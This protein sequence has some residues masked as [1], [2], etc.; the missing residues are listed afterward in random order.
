MEEKELKG[1][2]KKRN[3]NRNRGNSYECVICKELR[4]LGFDVVTSRSESKNLDNAKVDVFDKEGIL[5]SIQIKK[6]L[7]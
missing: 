6:T 1:S 2:K 4:E 3:T 7:N 5:P